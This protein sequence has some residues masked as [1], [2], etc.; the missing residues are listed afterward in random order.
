ML[1]K[2]L[3]TE[4]R[5]LTVYFSAVLFIG[6]SFGYWREAAI[7]ALSTC[8]VWQFINLK[9]LDN[10]IHRARSGRLHS[11]EL[12]GIWGEMAED[13]H[14]ILIR[15]GK[16]KARLQSVVTRVQEMTA[17][18]TDGVVLADSRGNLEWWNQAAATML[19]LKQ[20]DF[21]HPLTNIVR[22]PQF[23]SYFDAHDYGEPLEME[24]YRNED[25]RL[26]FE[27]HPYGHGERLITIRDISRVAK[28]EQMRRDF[29]ANVSHELRTPL[30]VIRGYVE[31]LMD[32]PGLNPTLERAL[33]QM[34]QQGLRMTA[35]VND[36]IMLTKLET[37][38]RNAQKD[39]VRLYDL[40]ALIFNDGRAV[41]DND[42]SYI[43]QVDPNLYLR[44]SEKE[45]RSAL[46]NLVINA[47]KYASNDPSKPAQIRVYTERHGDNVSLHVE[48]NG[49]GIDPKHIPRLTERFYRVDAGRASTAGGTG[50]GLAIVKHVLIRHDALL[51]IASK[52]NRGSTFTCVFPSERIVSDAKSA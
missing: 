47:V 6:A 9:K 36:L 51:R 41:S 25:L 43:N 39:E 5:W 31:T 42:H 34:Q 23:Q 27:V 38:D 49:V 1:R 3:G 22:D 44:G 37:D 20:I 29:V 26:L 30:T 45:L 14:R 24:S 4:I 32:M 28:L 21:G 12:Q 2:S 48:D 50:L 11:N 7:F 33:G 35:L 10:W 18:L 19:G 16:E 15:H 13:V 17:A 46:S 8:V 40:I 52:P